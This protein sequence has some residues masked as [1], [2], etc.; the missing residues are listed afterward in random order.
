[1]VK[2]KNRKL[3]IDGFNYLWNRKHVHKEYNSQ[4]KCVEVLTVYLEGFKS[5]PLRIMF[6][7]IGGLYVIG[8]PNDGVIWNKENIYN[9]NKPKIVVEIIKYALHLAW[10]PMQSRTTFLVENGIE[11]LQHIQA[12]DDV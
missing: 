3:S 9:L 5:S 4:K 7:D 10:N 12:C 1:M 11:I 8:Y 6:M 2:Y